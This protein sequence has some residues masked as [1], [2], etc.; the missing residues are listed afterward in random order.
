MRHRSEL[1]SSASETYMAPVSPP[2]TSSMAPSGSSATTRDA[3]RSPRDPRG[4]YVPKC[5]TWEG[6]HSYHFRGLIFTVIIGGRK[7]K[8]TR[9]DHFVCKVTCA[10]TRCIL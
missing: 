10:A 9:R 4:R 7:N 8:S 3:L 6:I 1:T 5:S 2:H